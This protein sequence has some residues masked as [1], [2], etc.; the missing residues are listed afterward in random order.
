MCYP[1]PPDTRFQG[2]S[3]VFFLFFLWVFRIIDRGS[4]THNN[5]RAR[6]PHR[7][8]QKKEKE[9]LIASHTHSP[10]R[11]THA[12]SPSPPSA[13]PSRRK[14]KKKQQRNIMA[15]S[16][17]MTVGGARVVP[18]T[19]G[20]SSVRPVAATRSSFGWRGSIAGASLTGWARAVQH[21]F[22]ECP[23]TP[24]R[25]TLSIFFCRGALNPSAADTFCASALTQIFAQLQS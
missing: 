19:R 7:V 5:N 24:M 9:E 14:K 21:G 6:S 12:V 15:S 16:A 3:G 13:N 17:M 11:T 18:V 23:Q 2:L 22:R 25:L 4:P 20:S 10:S 1:L 8:S